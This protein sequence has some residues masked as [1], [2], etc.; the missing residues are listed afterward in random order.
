[1]S[2]SEVAALRKATL[3]AHPA[4][5]TAVQFHPTEPW[6]VSGDEAGWCFWWSIS[7]RRP[8]AIWK[9]HEKAIVT[10][11]WMSD[12]ESD[13]NFTDQ[14]GSPA[15]Q[16][17]GNNSNSTSSDAGSVNSGTGDS[18]SGAA[19][20][21]ERSRN[22][23]RNEGTSILLTHGRDNKIKIFRL[24]T[25]DPASERY[26]TTIPID[27]KGKKSPNG[28]SN[29]DGSNSWKTPWMVHSQD[30]NAMNFCAAA[31]C[32]TT[33]AVPNTLDSEKIDI[34]QLRPEFSRPFF[35]IQGK[36]DD[37]GKSQ[38]TTSSN[39]SSAEP[40]AQVGGFDNL[41][42][43]GIGDEVFGD[44]RSITGTGILMAVILTKTHLIA[45]YESGHVI[46]FDITTSG[47]PKQVYADKSHQ[48][49]VLS[50]V[51]NKVDDT[52]LSS[53][54]DSLIIK[55]S[56]SSSE[57]LHVLNTKHVGLTSLDLRSDGRI[58]ATAGWDGMV[59]IYTYSSMK[60]LAAFRGSE[61]R[62]TD[63]TG[64]NSVT[65]SPVQDS[66][67]DSSIPKPNESAESATVTTSTRQVAANSLARARQRRARQSHWI[68]VA[69]KDGRIRLSDI[70]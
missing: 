1:M 69:S 36:P 49:P 33:I 41:G 10:V 44:K 7:Q 4:P 56:I 24:N 50:L 65:F 55:H 29:P 5:V 17:A 25:T 66:E 14:N 37:T 16:P 46:V 40:F 9:P 58:F 32:G 39:P 59:R 30:V 23:I 60:T 68:A 2:L 8:I 13:P 57:P 54:A 42:A 31:V 26:T 28:N 52:F 38:K 35:A 47:S 15:D 3:R 21:P 67:D 18:D 19:D 70:Y 62:L 6:L 11:K 34:Y 64:I 22:P 45:G 61:G 63:K 53:S 51:Y 20:L 48:H 27:W 12:W 43:P